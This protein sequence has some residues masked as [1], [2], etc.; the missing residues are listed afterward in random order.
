MAMMTV[1]D[2]ASMITETIFENR[3]MHVPELRRMG[4]NITVQGAR[5]W[6][7]ASRTAGRR[8][9]HGTDLRASVRW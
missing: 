7:A 8:A 3:F 6:S 4:A 1:A 9:G 5:H 2:G